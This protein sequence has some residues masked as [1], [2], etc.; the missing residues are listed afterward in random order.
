MRNIHSTAHCIDL[1]QVII[2]RFGFPE[3]DI[4]ILPD[5][6]GTQRMPRLTGLKTAL[7]IIPTGKRFNTAQAAKW[8]I[9]DKVRSTFSAF[10]SG[11]DRDKEY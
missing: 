3:V 9:V 8:G 4:G 1:I 10:H 5:G 7:E 6:G 2:C 11:G